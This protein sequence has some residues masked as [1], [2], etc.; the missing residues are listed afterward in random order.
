MSNTPLISIITPCFNHGIYL[1]DAIESIKKISTNYTYEHIIANDGST[2]D[3]TI[4]KLKEL[5]KKGYNV[6]HQPNMGLAAARNNAIDASKGK[7]I[8]PLDS[9]NKLHANYLTTA[10]NVLEKKPGIDIVYADAQFFE[11]ENAIVKPGAFDIGRIALANYIDACA[12]IRKTVFNKIG[13]YDGCMPAMGNE[14]WEFWIRAFVNGASFY[15]LNEI[16]FYYRVTQSSMRLGIT[17][18]NFEANH[19]YILGKLGDKVIRAMLKGF[20]NWNYIQKNKVKAAIQLL[21]GRL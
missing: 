15:Y 11:K 20:N 5:Q 17:Q 2:D 3:F 12:V 16:G 6:I 10:I 14:D 13:G 4:N 9:D 21:T 18:N 7:Y 1:D 19:K 8:L